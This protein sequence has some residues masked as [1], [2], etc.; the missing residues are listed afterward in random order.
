MKFLSST[1]Q[2]QHPWFQNALQHGENE[3]FAE[4]TQP[5]D[6]KFNFSME[7]NLIKAV[8]NGKATAS[9]NGKLLAFYL[10][11]IIKQYARYDKQY[12]DG[13]F[14][15]NHDQDRILSQV[16][17]EEKAK[18]V[19]SVYL[20]LPGNPFIYYGEEIGMKGEKPDECIREPFKWSED[21][22]D[23]DTT[24]E[25]NTYNKDT[26]SAE[27]LTIFHNFSE[28]AVTVNW[29]E[30]YGRKI[31]YQTVDG[32]EVQNDQVLLPPYST[33]IFTTHK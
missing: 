22:K 23:M 25:K 2:D 5:F 12:L 29:K 32:C 11:D 13:V 28:N 6:T 8:Q 17:S 31:L 24:W 4:Y 19:A 18:L 10:D 20:T 3:I 30:E 7:Q 15:S 27:E 33:V 21:G 14:G 26:D 16:E 1:I 9:E